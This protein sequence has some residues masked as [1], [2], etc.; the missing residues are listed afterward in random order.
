M[1]LPDSAHAARPWR[2]HEFAAD[3]ELEDVWQLP[4]PGGRNDLPRLVRQFT[5][6]DDAE[7][8]GF[9]ARTLFAI[10][11][12]I[13]KLFD[14]DAEADGVGARVSTLRDRLPQDLLDGP[15]GPDFA[16]IPFRSVYQ[17]DDEWVAE[18]ANRTVHGLLHIGWVHDGDDRYHAQMAVLVR[19]N[20][21]LGKAYLAGIKTIRRVLVYPELIRSIGRRWARQ[22]H[23]ATATPTGGE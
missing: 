23:R 20:G 21:A 18:L 16:L 6:E 9:A 7:L 1:R 5:D 22:S 15:R 8:S 11:W 14:W 10:R 17:T 3:F 4:T 13:G 2:I 12:E 19:P